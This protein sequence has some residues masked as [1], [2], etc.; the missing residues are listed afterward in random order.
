MKIAMGCDHG[1]YALKEDIKNLLTGKGYEVVDCGTYSTDSCDYPVFGEAAA[2]KVASGECEYGI[3][4]C[5]TGI[6]ISIAANK[7]RGIRC[8]HCTDTLS[9]E[10]TRR[11]NNANMLAIGAGITGKNLAERMVEVFLSTEFEGGRHARR[12]ALLD[13]IEN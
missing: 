12:V 5:T 1:G 8:A 6:G 2:R 7:V 3:V 13:A 11:H 9:A 10:M 4:I